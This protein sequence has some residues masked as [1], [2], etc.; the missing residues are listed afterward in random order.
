MKNKQHRL[1][2]TLLL[3]CLMISVGVVYGR[4]N[5]PEI[6][7]GCHD[8]YKKIPS[9][10]GKSSG[11]AHHPNYYKNPDVECRTCHTVSTIQE[12]DCIRCHAPELSPYA[13]SPNLTSLINNEYLPD[14]HHRNVGTK[15]P[16]DSAANYKCMSCHYSELGPNG[17]VFVGDWGKCRLDMAPKLPADF[18]CVEK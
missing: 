2:S 9:L 14:R 3:I 15:I 10:V 4:I 5:D 18:V 13:I 17:E 8:G 16:G 7:K 12:K 11:E 6:C 1:I